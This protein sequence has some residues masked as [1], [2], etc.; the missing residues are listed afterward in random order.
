MNKNEWKQRYIARFVERAK[1]YAEDSF[2]A[3]DYNYD[4]DNP[5]DCAD[6]EMELMAED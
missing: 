2:E 6:E 5:E 1:T 3:G 4:V